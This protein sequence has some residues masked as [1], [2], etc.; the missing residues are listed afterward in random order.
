MQQDASVA[1]VTVESNGC[2][3]ILNRLK[4][5]MGNPAADHE[6]EALGTLFMHLLS[7]GLSQIM[8]G[9][10]VDDLLLVQLLGENGKPS[11]ETL[12]S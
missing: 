2:A 8:H 9:N 10:D 5:D 6:F 3:A 1:R 7:G 11:F 12:D 4:A